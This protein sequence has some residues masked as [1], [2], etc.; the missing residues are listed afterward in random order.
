VDARID[1]D[2]AIVG[3][4]PAGSAAAIS[5][6]ERGLRVHLFERGAFEGSGFSDDRPGETLHPGIEPVLVQLG[7]AED[8]DAVVGARHEG[9]WIDWAGVRRFQPFG[10]DA[11]GPWRGFQVS[12]AAFDT[13]LLARAQAVGATIVQPCRVLGLRFDGKR[14]IGVATEIGS[15]SARFVVDATGR[16]HWIARR[17]RVAQPACS[18]RLIARYGY[19]RGSCPERDAAP[20]LVGD[21]SGWIWTARIGDSLYQW[22]RVTTINDRPDAAWLPEELCGLAPLGPTRGADVTW[23]IA[24][25]VASSGWFMV[26]DAAAVLDPT[27]SHGVLKALLSGIA[28]AHL[29]D[30]VMATK[31]P[32]TEAAAI[33]QSWLKEWFAND[34]AHLFAF[35]GNIGMRGFGA[36][37]SKTALS[38]HYNYSN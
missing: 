11:A 26:G 21:R 15:V 33:Y 35:Y 3:G 22:I 20:A 38:A 37:L 8:L 18:P 4:G 23:R 5:C 32:P 9:I 16:S 13:M 34:A 2:V 30:A 27:S 7:V 1:T 17:L 24:D 36:P 28:A 31:L 25:R 19:A 10:R 6:A 14:V 12:R 29:I